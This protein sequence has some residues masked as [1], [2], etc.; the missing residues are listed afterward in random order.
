MELGQTQNPLAE[1]LKTCSGE[2]EKRKGLTVKE[3]SENKT[4]GTG[5]PDCRP[6]SFCW[7]NFITFSLSFLPRG[8]AGSLRA[9][10]CA[11]MQEGSASPGTAGD[12]RATGTRAHRTQRRA[13]SP[14]FSCFSACCHQIVANP[15]ITPP[16]I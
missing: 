12:S 3:N 15:V 14:I 6:H 13:G 7:S 2:K 16:G 11:N 10:E 5:K 4:G 8:P 9:E 1:K